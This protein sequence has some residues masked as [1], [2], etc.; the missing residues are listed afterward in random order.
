[1]LAF[2]RNIVA[3][4]NNA[5][6]VTNI[7]TIVLGFR[8]ILQAVKHTVYIQNDITVT[9]RRVI[10]NLLRYSNHCVVV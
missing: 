8:L 3:N 9:Q 10:V 1:M 5:K 6:D 2:S 7:N 4:G